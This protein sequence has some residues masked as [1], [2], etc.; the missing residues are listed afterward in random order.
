[1]DKL[2]S[3]TL[4][5]YKSDGWVAILGNVYD[6]SEFSEIHPGGKELIESVYGTD[7]TKSF[8]EVHP[9][10]EQKLLNTWGRPRWK[11]YHKAK[12]IE[13]NVIL[14]REYGLILFA[15]L[16]L[17]LLGVYLNNKFITFV[18]LTGIIDFGYSIYITLY[19]Y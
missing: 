15:F 6:L 12:F 16:L 1:M 8:L 7:A 17:S 19:N 18:F 13:N 10:G 9:S 11:T 3:D 5:K 14:D 2:N 4:L